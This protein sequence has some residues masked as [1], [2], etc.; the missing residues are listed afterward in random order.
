MD[1]ALE[2]DAVIVQL[3]LDLHRKSIC[4]MR[5]LNKIHVIT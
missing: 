4:N 3:Y 1:K 2:R 5:E